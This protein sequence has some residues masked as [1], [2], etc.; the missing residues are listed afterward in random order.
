MEII[1]FYLIVLLFGL[2]IGSFLGVII[3]RIPFNKSIIFPASHCPHCRHKLHAFD[4]IPIVSFIMLNKKC[5][6]CSAP[7]SGFYPTV[8]FITGASF[9]FIAYFSLGNSVFNI[10]SETALL[11]NTLYLF[12]VISAFIAVFFIDYKYGIIP[13]RIVIFTA[14][15]I[16][17]YNILL[18]INF[19][20]WLNY[21]LSAVIVFTVF[22]MLFYFSKGRAIG[23]GDVVF[24]FLMGF[25]LGFPKI[26]LAV[27][28]AFLT[29]AAFSLIL[30]LLGKKKLKGGTIPFGPFLVTGTFISLFWG[31]Q[32]IEYFMQFIY[33]S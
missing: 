8:E 9:V 21:L 19:E 10:F 14:S 20:S 26:I 23:F 24:S 6:Y 16:F 17:I 5:R 13:F 2:F 12:I 28:L 11:W 31:Q 4:L 33:V 3:D 22:F 15:V 7:I 29:G 18:G 32:I 27:Y 30:V 1:I 25:F